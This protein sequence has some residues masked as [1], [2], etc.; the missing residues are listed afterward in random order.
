MTKYQGLLDQSRAG[1]DVKRLEVT[2][3]GIRDQIGDQNQGD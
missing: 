3:E 1:L 2:L